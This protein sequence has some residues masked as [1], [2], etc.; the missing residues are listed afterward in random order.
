M[1]GIGLSKISENSLYD[2]LGAAYDEIVQNVHPLR[3]ARD[4][5]DTETLLRTRQAARVLGVSVSTVKRWV[6]AGELRACRT[7][8][9]HRLISASEVLRFA[10]S[11]DLPAADPVARFAGGGGAEALAAALEGGRAGEA[12]T[13]IAATYREGG[14][15]AELADE[16]IRPAMERIGH[17]WEAGHLDVFQEH[18]ATR[19]VESALLGL[20][21]RAPP[22][23]RPE[24][25]LALGASVE[26]DPYTLPGLLAELTLRE[27]GW[28]AI[29]LG[30]SLPLASLARALRALRPRLAWLS[31]NYLADP[32]R[33]LAEFRPVCRAAGEA[34]V[35]VVVGGQAF[36]P[37]LRDRLLPADFAGRMGQLRDL[38]GRLHANRPDPGPGMPDRPIETS[39][40][41][42]E[43]RTS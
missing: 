14:D 22:S 42:P 37:D 41:H 34:G 16:L 3:G 35:A 30:P 23:S 24:A 2:R 25:P 20:I 36:T 33:F 28:E 26:G 39:G 6:D 38:A 8:G 10:Q 32:D 1:A 40:V 13:I 21:H 9:R 7:V 17:G 12:Q 18:R 11:R 27:R 19:I 29:N 15:A 43:R 4:V 5:A 31:A